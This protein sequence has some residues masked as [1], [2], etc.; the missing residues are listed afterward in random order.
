MSDEKKRP[1]VRVW[2]G[3][4]NAWGEHVEGNVYRSLNHTFSNV[5]LK[6]PEGH[7]FAHKNGNPCNLRWGMLFEGDVLEPG[8]V[9]PL[10]IIG[11]DKTPRDDTP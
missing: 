1:L 5:P 7:A 9:K 6:L 3:D 10:F 4:E 11:E 2:F 8:R